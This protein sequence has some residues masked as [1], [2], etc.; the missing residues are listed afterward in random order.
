MKKENKCYRKSGWG[1]NDNSEPQSVTHSAFII[2][3]NLPDSKH[4]I[5]PKIKDIR[6]N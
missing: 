4:L 6:N 2:L 5:L 1:Y 3:I